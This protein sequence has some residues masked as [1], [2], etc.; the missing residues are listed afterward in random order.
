MTWFVE[1]KN[2]SL[3][4]LLMKEYKSKVTALRLEKMK[5]EL[6]VKSSNFESI[7]ANDQIK[8]EQREKAV[9]IS[10]QAVY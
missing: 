8:E 4:S 5:E 3:V 10:N 7:F 1:N 6:Q 2:P 9:S